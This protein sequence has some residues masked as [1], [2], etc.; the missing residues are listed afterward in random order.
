MVLMNIWVNIWW[1]RMS[2]KMNELRPLINIHVQP[3][4]LPS[5]CLPS[6][7]CG[8]TEELDLAAGNCIWLKQSFKPKHS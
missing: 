2:R 1:Q 7:C 4:D 3:T 8:N 5:L 6:S